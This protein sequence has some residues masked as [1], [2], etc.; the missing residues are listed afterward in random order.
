MSKLYV[1][2]KEEDTFYL[3]EESGS[4]SPFIIFFRKYAKILIPLLLLLLFLT[5]LVTIKSFNKSDE[6]ALETEGVNVIFPD[7]NSVVINGTE[8]KDL[9]NV[10]YEMLGIPDEVI[11]VIRKIKLNNMEITYYSDKTAKIVYNNGSIYRILPVNNNYG[12]DENGIVS[13]QAKKVKLT[14]KNTITNN[15][16]TQIIYSDGSSELI[17]NDVN[18]WVGNSNNIKENF[19]TSNKI[20]YIKE[21]KEYPNFTV[22]K[23]YDGTITI[24]DNGKKYIVR[25]EQ[26][27]TITDKGYTFNND[28]FA[29]VIETKKLNNSITIEYLSDGG[30]II[31]DKDGL[32]EIRKSNSIVIKNNELLYIK[33]S[34]VVKV[35]STKIVGDYEI[36]YYNNGNSI[37]KENGQIIGYIKENTDPEIHGDNISNLEELLIPYSNKRTEDGK[38]III[39]E[40]NV[41]FVE[42]KDITYVSEDTKINLSVNFDNGKEYG[43]PTRIIINNSTEDVIKYRVVLEKSESTTL[44]D[45]YLSEIKY[46]FNPSDSPKGINS[47]LWNDKDHQNEYILYE[48]TID[49][50]TTEELIVSFWLDYENLQNDAMNKYFYGT[51]KV[52]STTNLND[53]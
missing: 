17:D 16:G 6:Y 11:L 40:D 33:T 44:Q 37:V 46:V 22:E 10:Y 19:I 53:K 18:I 36:D 14:I 35:V 39:F 29:T 5:V 50:K 24:I 42:T 47:N 9:N 2:K 3:G 1:I 7:D 30:A 48:S 13:E 12:V 27:V 31:H 8:E 26:D 4:G 45:K 43:E 20:T 15:H 49:K 34:N 41:S 21:I 23:R 38:T 52:Y 25:K 51:L 32:L 28:N